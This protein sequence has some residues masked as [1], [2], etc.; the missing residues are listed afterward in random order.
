MVAFAFNTFNHSKLQ[1]M[2]MVETANHHLLYLDRGKYTDCYFNNQLIGKITGVNLLYSPRKRLIGRIHK[3]QDANYSSLI[4]KDQEVA[5]FNPIE[6]DG[7]FN[8]RVFDIV[9]KGISKE[10]LLVLMTLSFYFLIHE[11][12]KLKD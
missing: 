11:L 5:I 4:Y 7:K 3:G 12:L 1:K 9:K 6:Y 10:E 8:K 2:I